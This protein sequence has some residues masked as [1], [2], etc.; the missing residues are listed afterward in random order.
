MGHF[1]PPGSGTV[2]IANMNPDPGTPL[3]PD[4]IPQHFIFIM[5]IFNIYWCEILNWLLRKGKVS[6]ENKKKCI[7]CLKNRRKKSQISNEH[8]FLP[9]YMLF[10]LGPLRNLLRS[11]AVLFHDKASLKLL[12]CCSY[13]DEH[14]VLTVQNRSS[15][16][17]LLALKHV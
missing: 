7:F 14:H 11:V 6:L 17:L 9:A 8:I 3:N 15:P 10:I 12:K 1:C 5:K 2:W 16:N 13:N 4:P